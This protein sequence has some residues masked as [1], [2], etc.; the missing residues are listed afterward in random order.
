MTLKEQFQERLYKAISE[1]FGEEILFSLPDLQFA[2]DLRFGDFQWDGAMA[3]AKSSEKNSR[4]IAQSIVDCLN[5]Q[6]LGEGSIAGP[7]F[8]NIS[9][10]PSVF[11]RIL[12]EM[13][14]DEHLGV[15]Q[16]K[17]RKIVLDFSSPN[18]AKPMHVGH[19]RSTIIGDCLSRVAS[20]LGYEVISVNH[21]GDWGTQ[22]GMVIYGWKNFLKKEDL[23]QNPLDVLV[24]IYQKVNA[25]CAEDDSIREECKGELIKLQKGEKQNLKIW[26][27]C[28]ALCK[29]S[30]QEIYQQ[31]GIHFDYYLGESFYQEKLA[32]LVDNLVA[33]KVAR[34]SDGAIAVFSD[35][36]LE[37]KRDPFLVFRE[38]DWQNSPCLIRKADGC[39]LYAT[40]DLAAIAYRCEEWNA[41]E[42]WYVV[43]FPQKIHF[44]QVFSTAKRANLANNVKLKHISHGSILGED[45]KLMRTRSGE[46]VQLAEVILKACEKANAIILEKNP[47]LSEKDRLQVSR[48]V[49]VGALKFSELFQ[50]RLTDYTFSYEKMLSLK[51]DSSPYLQYSYVRIQSLLRKSGSFPSSFPKDFCPTEKQEIHLARLLTRFSDVVPSILDD[52]RPNLLAQYLV[53]LAKSF[54]SFFEA[55]PVLN[56]DEEILKSRLA[57]CAMSAKILYQG[58]Y[59]LGIDAPERM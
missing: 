28:V 9:V 25:L 7:G 34:Q 30:L 24:K 59:L 46:Q 39:F 26:N 42:I 38:D 37:K 49:G 18:I 6:G 5:L 2:K 27:E 21:L 33:K 52:F 13:F 3:L 17:F 11:F 35:G 54:H 12:N 50:H 23:K 51:G 44:A 58:L 41:D 29:S 48:Q 32:S 19:I 1:V 57:L 15:K 40:T 45:G 36:S 55:C 53:D 4:E 22:F 47:E 31:L 10:F 20:F 43:G 16:Q 8:I 56:A 14:N